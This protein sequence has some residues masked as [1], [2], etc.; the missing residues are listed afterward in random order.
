LLVSGAS[1]INSSLNV[2]G[3]IIGSGTAL[4]NLNYNAITNPPAIVSFNNPATF[5]SSLNVSGT[6]T[7]NN[8]TTCMSSL[9]VSGITILNSNV[10]I[11]ALTPIGKLDVRGTIYSQQLV[12]AD[13]TNIGALNNYQL[14]LTPASTTYQYATIQS[15]YNTVFSTTPPLV[16]QPSGGNVGIGTTNNISSKITIN[17][18]VNDRWTYDHSTSPLTITNQTGTGTTLN[19]PQG[20]QPI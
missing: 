20:P 18:I 1:T 15:I 11:G 17:D 13:I 16:L 14:R 8:V 4:T 5:V 9:N 12:L 2:V 6:T 7:L 10:G 19:D 3:N